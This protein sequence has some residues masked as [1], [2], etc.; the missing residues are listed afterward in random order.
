MKQIEVVY[1]SHTVGYKWAQNAMPGISIANDI[2]KI[3][4]RTMMCRIVLIVNH[5]LLVQNRQ[6]HNF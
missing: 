5:I 6:L 1:K 2:F 4:I 3:N